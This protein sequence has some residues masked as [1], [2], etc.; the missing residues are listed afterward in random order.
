MKQLNVWAMLGIWAGL[1]LGAALYAAW[2][3]YG[4]RAFAATVA[5]FS[6]LLLVMLG[7]AARGVAEG[8]AG[9]F[10]PAG[11]LLLG[12]FALVAF[13]TCLVGTGSFAVERAGAMAAFV[14]VPL[15]LAVS[16]GGAAAG[17]WQ[18]FLYVVGVWVFVKFGPTHW[19]WPYPGGRL[20]YVFTVLM[21]VDVALACFLL[22]RRAKGVGCSI[23]WGK[24]WGLYVLGSLVVFGCVAIPLGIRMRFIAFDP[25][26][27]NW[28]GLLAGSVGILFLTAWPG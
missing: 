15:G 5:T 18:D 13:V 6:I 24:R 27:G 3:G 2:E 9:K 11:G 7:F 16:S 28:R 25:H 20:A 12:A 14:F 23:G 19:M 22:V 17:A 26:W 1:S 21:A 8:L 4:G 10:G